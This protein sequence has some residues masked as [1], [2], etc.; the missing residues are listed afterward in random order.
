MV[1]PRYRSG[2][3]PDLRER[4]FGALERGAVRKLNRY[5]QVTLVFSADERGGQPQDAPY[6]NARENERE[7]GHGGTAPGYGTDN[8]EIAG[9][10]PV[11]H[12][13][14]AAIEQVALLARN[15]AAEPQRAL[16]RL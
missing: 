14:E 15:L 6:R 7:H 11:V 16:R 10:D 9:L 4:F 13:I 8:P 3:L 2:C 12:A 1:H 5:H